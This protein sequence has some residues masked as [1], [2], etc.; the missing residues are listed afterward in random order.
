MIQ[1][2]T[3]MTDKEITI[4]TLFGGRYNLLEAYLHS[5]DNLDYPKEQLSVIW[6]SNCDSETFK[7]ILNLEADKRRANYKSFEVRFETDIPSSPMVVEEGKGSEEHASIIAKLYNRAFALVKTELFFC[8][9]DDTIVPAFTLKKL[10]THLAD[11]KVVYVCGAIFCRHQGGLFAWNVK[12][13]RRMVQ[14]PEKTQTFIDDYIGV[15]ISK[16]W[17]IRKVG[18]STLALSLIRTQA[19]KDIGINPFKSRHTA[20]VSLIGCDMV[21]CLDFELRNLD[22]VI[23]FDIR[24]L[25]FDSKA[26]PH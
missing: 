17:G 1:E 18:V 15:P 5:F 3:G 23:D 19:V 24:A 26:R 9:E 10:L 25:H 8:L 6:M 20:S 2:K 16:P 12:R 13:V 11:P 4:V 7:T 21:L 22:R 14:T